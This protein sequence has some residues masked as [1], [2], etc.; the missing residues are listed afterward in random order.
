MQLSSQYKNNLNIIQKLNWGLIITMITLLIIGLINLYSISHREDSITTHLFYLQLIWII[1]GLCIFFCVSFISYHFL[2]KIAYVLYFLNL[3][4][5]VLVYF[6]GS[7]F[8]GARRWLDFGLLTY[9]PAETI[10][11]AL[12]LILARILA[13]KR[14]WQEMNW[15]ELIKPL[16]LIGI[17]VAL[18]IRQPDLGTALMIL[19]ITGSLITFSKVQKSILISTLA[20][21]LVTTP[22]VWSFG[23]KPYQKNRILTFLYP[24]QDPRGTGYNTIQSKIAIGSGKFLGKGFQKGTQSQLEFLPE[25]HTD[26]IF[27]VLSE[28]HGFV[29]SLVTLFLFLFLVLIGFHT[30]SQARDKVGVFLCAGM[31]F[32]L[33]W[34]IFINIGMTMGL[35]PIVGVPLPLLSYGGS[36]MVSTMAA[37]GVI[38]SVSWR[39]YLF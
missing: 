15:T 13:A 20:L 38:S 11:L 14:S 2:S 6:Q 28:E 33:F 4:A 9:Q 31:S 30:A 34:H 22:V 12:I 16:M 37:L 18:I 35:L 23:L 24:S 1:I 36:S 21:M 17:P 29:G 32:Y 3:F 5:L 39:R 27:S 10:K 26:F 8:G 7:T 25:R 19:I